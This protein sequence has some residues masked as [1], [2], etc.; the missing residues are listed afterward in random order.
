MG[1]EQVGP[2]VPAA[3]PRPLRLRT[4]TVQPG[5]SSVQPVGSIGIVNVAKRKRHGGSRQ[6]KDDQKTQEESQ[7]K[8]RGLKG[9]AAQQR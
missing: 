6:E 9:A 5:E 1:G 2:T 3:L 8:A 7:A 4:V